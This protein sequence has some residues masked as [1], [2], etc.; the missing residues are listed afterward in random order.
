M[1]T[2][3]MRFL[4]HNAFITYQHPLVIH[5]CFNLR[6]HNTLIKHQPSLSCSVRCA[7]APPFHDAFIVHFQNFLNRLST[8]F[9]NA[10]FIMPLFSV[11]S[12]SFVCPLFHNVCIVHQ[13][14]LS[15]WFHNAI[16]CLDQRFHNALSGINLFL[17]QYNFI[18]SFFALT[19]L[20]N[21]P[22]RISLSFHHALLMHQPSFS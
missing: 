3:A 16:S 11:M 10:L 7:S 18:M 9:Y 12:F 13:P 15:Y 1:N 4:F 21:I 5:L 19:L 2:Y 17:L 22:S 6:F 20:S 8:L 14:S